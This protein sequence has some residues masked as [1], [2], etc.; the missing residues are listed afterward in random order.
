MFLGLYSPS[1][2]INVLTSANFEDEV[3]QRPFALFVEFYNSYCGACQRFAPT[4]KAVA[5]NITKWNGIVRMGAMDCASDENN[6]VCRKY[7]IMRYPTMR[8][9]PPHYAQGPSQLGINLDH[10]L[11]PQRDELIDE[12][13]KHLVNET[14]GGPEWPKFEKFEGKKWKQIF[15]GTSLDTKYVYLVSA[16]LPGLLPQQVQLDHVGVDSIS[17]RVVDGENLTLIQVN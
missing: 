2:S 5:L 7:E 17:V 3:F 6:D 10:L 11:V 8:Y 15:N 14:N 9:F 1:D 16:D 13:T 12:L 4:W